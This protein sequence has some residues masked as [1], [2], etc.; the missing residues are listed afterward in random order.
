MHQLNIVCEEVHISKAKL[1]DNHT[2]D[3]VALLKAI[4]QIDEGAVIMQ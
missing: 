2:E 4:Q 3:T 1:W